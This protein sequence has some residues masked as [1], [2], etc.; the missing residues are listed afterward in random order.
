MVGWLVGL[1]FGM[2]VEAEYGG[3]M[4]KD[5]QKSGCEAS[6]MWACRGSPGLKN[7][8]GD[9]EDVKKDIPHLEE[10]WSSGNQP[11]W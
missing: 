2:S 10:H 3:A 1:G 6:P 7:G 4:E 9:I 8:E 5:G 11:V